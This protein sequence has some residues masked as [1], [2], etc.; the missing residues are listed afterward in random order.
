[1]FFQKLL[2]MLIVGKSHHGKYYQKLDIKYYCVKLTVLVSP[3]MRWGGRRW[4]G[5]AAAWYFVVVG[6]KPN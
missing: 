5:Q 3:G 6:I 4:N 2:I 1:M